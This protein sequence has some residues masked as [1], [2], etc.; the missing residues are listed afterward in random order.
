VYK[1]LAKPKILVI[2]GSTASGK[3]GLAIEL[4]KRFNGEVISADSRQVYRGLD[5]GT[6]K[7][8]EEEMEGIPHHL[9][10]VANPMEGYSAANFKNDARTSINDIA[11]RGKLPIV[12]GGTFF[13]VDTLLGR[14]SLPE[15]E[16]NQALR[17]SLEEKSTVELFTTLKEKDPE[18]AKKIDPKNKRRLVRALEI[19]HQLEYVPK[20]SEKRS[21]FAFLIIGIEA[22]K[23][24]LRNKF[25]ERAKSWL[26]GGFLQEVQNLLDEGITRERLT[27]IGFEYR[28]GLELLDKEITEEEFIQKFI[29]KNWQYAKRQITWLKRDKEIQ[30]FKAAEDNVFKAVEDFIKT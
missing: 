17:H 4:A 23:E 15:V 12:A 13:Y 11:S 29:E 25:A 20:I 22:E 18:R 27:E 24:D 8:T 5:I 7:V 10:N 16:P 30:W 28:L 14:V 26:K 9:I 1:T 21:D 2:V 3:T 19:I 6:A